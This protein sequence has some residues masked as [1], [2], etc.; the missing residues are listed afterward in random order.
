[1]TP[2]E[3]CEVLL[4][5]LL[6]ATENLLKRNKDFYPIGAV[7]TQEGTTTY[8]AI[9]S[10]DEFPNSET[11]INDLITAHRKMAEKNEIKASGIAWN[12]AIVTF[13]GQKSDAIIVS[14]EHQG[15]YSVTVGLPYKLG[16]FKN[17]KFGELFAEEGKND[18]FNK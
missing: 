8:T 1:M 5:T 13:D 9:H 3:E 12:A 18:V 2:K 17:I 10:D 6:T 14:L 15:N 7:M 16:L 11:V 4:D